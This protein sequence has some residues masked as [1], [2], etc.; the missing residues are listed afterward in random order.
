MQDKF[1][2]LKMNTLELLSDLSKF[3]CTKK[4]STWGVFA[5]DQLPKE[6]ISRPCLVIC[7][8]AKS[9]HPGL[10]WNGIYFGAGNKKA[11][12]FD[13]FG[14]PPYKKEFRKFI[15][16]NSTSCV[17]NDKKIQGNYS[18][19]CG[20]YS[21]LFLYF[22]CK[23]HSMTKFIDEFSAKKSEL[24]DRKIRKMYAQMSAALNKKIR[25][26]NAN[27][28]GGNYNC[29]T[30]NQTCKALKKKKNSLNTCKNDSF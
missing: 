20:Q 27:Q 26:Q 14:R 25:A 11:E 24:N 19:V 18:T 1:K 3:A 23:N 30:C 28:T 9:S 7:N 12:F 15:K 2:V 29:I 6:K 21:I 13:S 17:H 22:R 5:L 16:N 10:H 4:Q 8:S